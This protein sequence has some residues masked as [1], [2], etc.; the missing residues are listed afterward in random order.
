MHP[1][2]S[3]AQI[4]NQMLEKG[5][6]LLTFTI[7][8]KNGISHEALRKWKQIEKKGFLV[9]TT[10]CLLP[11]KCHQQA[12]SEKKTAHSVAMEL[13]WGKKS[14]PKI[15]K[16]ED[17]W[18]MREQISHLC[19]YNLCCSYKDLEISPQWKILKRNYCGA[20]GFCDCGCEPACKS[21][22]FPSDYERKLEFL[23]YSTPRLGEKVRE[24][25]ELDSGE[26]KVKVKILPADFYKVE[27]KKRENRNRRIK[28]MKRH[29]KQ[30]Q[31]NELQK[32]R[33]MEETV[34]KN[35]DSFSSNEE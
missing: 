32:K 33:K 10:G 17:G 6:I 2:I 8:R 29:K 31:R 9:T 21:K 35:S 15:W 23:S 4:R 12:N 26:L 27:D 34:E 18:P 20:K 16:N 19:H 1:R 28:A 25:F 24:F 22:Y 11:A 13:F 5:A 3:E 7:E 30:K 14:D